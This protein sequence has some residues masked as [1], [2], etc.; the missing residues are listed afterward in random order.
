MVNVMAQAMSVPCGMAVLGCLR[1]PD[2]LAPAEEEGR[3][4]GEHWR[5]REGRGG[6]GGGGVGGEVRGGEGEII[7]GEKW[8]G[9][10]EERREGNGRRLEEGKRREENCR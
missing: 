4:R 5:E 2:M 10:L 6:V 7:G 3:G 1:S 8:G 9:G